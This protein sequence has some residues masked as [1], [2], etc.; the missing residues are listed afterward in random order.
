MTWRFN[1]NLIKWNLLLPS[2]AEHRLFAPERVAFKLLETSVIISECNMSESD[3]AEGK[4]YR[5]YIQSLQ[6]AGSTV[7]WDQSAGELWTVWYML[8][9]LGLMPLMH[10]LIKISSSRRN[11]LVKQAHNHVYPSSPACE[12]VGSTQLDT[13]HLRILL[14]TIL[15]FALAGCSCWWGMRGFP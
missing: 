3:I 1:Q 12:F 6:T 10:H 7:W 13:R 5:R 15:W 2:D 8:V 4:R 14:P 9:H 11:W